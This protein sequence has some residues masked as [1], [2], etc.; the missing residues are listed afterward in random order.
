MG[1]KK[2]FAVFPSKIHGKGFFVTKT[3]K[4][5]AAIGILQGNI[6]KKIN[7]N[8]K[9][10]LANPDWVGVGKNTWIDPRPPYKF[11]NHSCSPSAGIRGKIMLIARRDLKDGDEVTLDYSLIEGD[12]RWKM[13]CT[14]G[15]KNCRKVI[16]SVNFLPYTVYKRY[17]PYISTYFQALYKQSKRSERFV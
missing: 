3:I 14:C 17:L 7:K 4:K 2:N 15:S 13:K 10:V 12:P 5:G 16:R 1:M 6:R 9:D 11:I 8:K